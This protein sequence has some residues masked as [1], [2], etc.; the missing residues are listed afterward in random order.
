[1][2]Y[3]K[4]QTGLSLVKYDSVQNDVSLSQRDQLI[5]DALRRIQVSHEVNRNQGSQ[6]L[7]IKNEA[8]QSMYLDDFWE[9]LIYLL[10]HGYL[11]V[12]TKNGVKQLYWLVV[13][14][15]RNSKIHWRNFGSERIQI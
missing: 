6:P 8:Q 3:H 12:D 4:V 2:F 1:M 11:Y 13:Q 7:A 5:I 10:F 9:Y 15:Q 14:K